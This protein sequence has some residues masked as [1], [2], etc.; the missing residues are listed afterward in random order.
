MPTSPSSLIELR[1]S[2]H[3]LNLEFFKLLSER[4]ST[5]KSIQSLKPTTASPWRNYDAQRERELFESL[6]DEL[7]GLGPKELLAF[8]LLMEAHAGP[9]QYY[10][11]WSEGVHL[12]ELPIK[13]FQRT[14]PLL[15]KLA[16]PDH[17][18][19]LRLRPNFAFLQDS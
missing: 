14:N 16:L 12:L 19:A 18:A 1:H 11:A 4:R 3:K 17:F 9:Q 8:S 5:V 7:V 6:R 13:D 2:L 10:P 15:V